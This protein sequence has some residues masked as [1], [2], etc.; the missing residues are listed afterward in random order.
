VD[1]IVQRV[2]ADPDEIDRLIDAAAGVDNPPAA[3]LRGLLLLLR[4]RPAEALSAFGTLDPA[5]MPPSLLYA[6]HRLHQELAPTAPD[7]YLAALRPAV[8]EGRVRVLIQA[9]V[10]ALDGDLSAALASYM[11]SDPGGW[12]RYDLQA[13]RQIAAHQGLVSDLRELLGGA[14]ASG[15]LKESLSA[16]LR[17][18]ARADPQGPELAAFKRQLREEIETKTPAGRIAIESARQLLEDRRRFVAREYAELVDAH[19]TSEPPSLPTETVLLLF[20]ASVALDDT[21]EMDRWGQE[22]KRRHGDAEVSD[23]VAS[24][25]DSAR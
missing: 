5:T 14:L 16:P 9:R 6:P 10:H 3:Y 18:I 13:F 21:V 2:G 22:L 17:E 4:E 15:R 25:K 19:R 12:A 20:L 7:P 8:A 1:R 23:W 11:R 24:M